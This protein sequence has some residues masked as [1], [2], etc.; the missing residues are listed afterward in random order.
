MA[1]LKAQRTW[2]IVQLLLPVVL[3]VVLPRDLIAHLLWQSDNPHSL[4]K[5]IVI[6]WQS[7]LRRHEQVIA[8]VGLAAIGAAVVPRLGRWWWGGALVLLG[9]LLT[10]LPSLAWPWVLPL[11]VLNLSPWVLPGKLAWVPGIGVPAPVPLL[12]RL[13]WPTWIGLLGIPA[14]VGLWLVMDTL[15]DFKH[16]QDEL[17]TPWPAALE[18]PRVE[19]V[20][21]AVPPTKGDYHDIDIVGDRT[22]VVAEWTNRLTSYPGAVTW[23]LSKLWG[24][25][26]GEAM[27]SETDPR[28]GLTYYQGGLDHIA[29]ARWMGDHWEPGPR[30]QPFGVLLPITYMKRM[31]TRL[32]VLTINAYSANDHPILVTAD[33]PDL[34][35]LRRH[36]VRTADGTRLPTARDVEWLPTINRLVVAPD[37]GRR[38]YLVNPDDGLAEPWVEVPAMD[39]RPLW[40]AGLGRLI[41][42]LPTRM[43]LWLIDPKTGDIRK[44]PT[45]PGVRTAD[46]DVGRKLVFTA[47]VITGQVL[48]QDLESGA[49]VDRYGTL[50]PMVRN[51]AVNADK[52]ET[53]LSTWTTL[54]RIPYAS[55]EGTT[56]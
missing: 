19:V 35:N 36:E 8:M 31:G 10:L 26:L 44:L 41:M 23:K 56:P 43:E 38:L 21:R 52:G 33:L 55:H 9:A 15:A 29:S 2:V 22:L 7:L 37:M 30:S 1:H 14:G 53:W 46:I 39:G 32:A 18:D 40:S 24:P 4:V 45:Q 54:Y 11:V 20:E 16:Y 3:L 13:A 28:T 51:I 25:P 48:V 6:T 50:M 12:R 34:G 17:F 5:L 42:P 27:D 47:S 49:V